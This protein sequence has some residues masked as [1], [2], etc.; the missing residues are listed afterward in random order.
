MNHL[1]AH[2]E[3]NFMAGHKISEQDRTYW[4]ADPKELKKVYLEALPYLSLENTEVKT[5][6]S[7]EYNEMLKQREKEQKQYQEQLTK[8]QEQEEKL[9]SKIKMIDRIEEKLNKLG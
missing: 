3:A 8:L 2:E 7:D 5:I 4:R 6:H 9:D 1:H